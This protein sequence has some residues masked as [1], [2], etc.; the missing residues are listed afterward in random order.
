[1]KKLFVLLMLSVFPSISSAALNTCIGVYVGR[2]SIDSQAGLDKVVFLASP[3]H[4]SGSYWVNFN[5]WD[6]DAKKQALSIL[7]AAKASQHRVD[8][9]TTAVGSCSIGSPSQ[10][11]K[12]VFLSTN[13]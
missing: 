13:P 6:F 12:Q 8:V 7:L 5:G 11:L 4:G 10:T 2:I 1:M 9:Y 3:E